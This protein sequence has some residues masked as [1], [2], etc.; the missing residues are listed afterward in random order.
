VQY[1]HTKR[2]DGGKKEEKE[3]RAEIAASKFAPAQPPKLVVNNS[4]K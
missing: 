4:T 2:S 3:K 1:T